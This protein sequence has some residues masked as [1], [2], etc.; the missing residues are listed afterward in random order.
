MGKRYVIGKGSLR[1]PH[2]YRYHEM[3]A[4]PVWTYV[5]TEVFKVHSPMYDAND[6]GPMILAPTEWLAYEQVIISLCAA[7]LKLM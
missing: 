3:K 7:N 4:D 1:N 5:H 6:S 2:S